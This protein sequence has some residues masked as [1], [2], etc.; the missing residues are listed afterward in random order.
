MP[1]APAFEELCQAANRL[2]QVVL[3]GQEHDAE[4]LLVGVVEPG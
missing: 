3:M 4:M 1:F 2:A